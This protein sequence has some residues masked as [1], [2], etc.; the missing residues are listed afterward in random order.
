VAFIGMIGD[1]TTGEAAELIEADRAA[2][3]Q[4][5]NFTR[6]FA[7]RPAVYRAWLELKSAVAGT[8]DQRRYELVTLAAARGLGSSYCMLAHGKILADRF[9]DPETVRRLAA[10]HHT[11]GLSPVD[12]AVMDL[13]EKVARDARS[14]TEADVERLRALGLTDTAIFDVVVAA[15]A[16]SFFSKT[17]DALGVNADAS[18][19]QLEPELR[20]A[21]TIGRPIAEPGTAATVNVTTPDVE[22]VKAE[23]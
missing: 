17:L 10:D 12:V 5:P 6:L 19:A 20:A 1:E 7:H 13:A 22:T 23:E 8:M 4:V 2:T 14:V 18:Y 15:T 3:G 16:R 21:L 11:A 9:F